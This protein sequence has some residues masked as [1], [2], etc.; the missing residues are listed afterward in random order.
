VPCGFRASPEDFEVEEVPSYG[1]SGEGDHL[2]LWIEKRCIPTFEAAR[3]LAG[4]LGIPPRDVGHAGL[5]DAHAVT[6]QQLSLPAPAPGDGAPAFDPESLVG[7]ELDGL[8]VLGAGRHG[9][10]LRRGHLRANRFRL[11]LRG[12]DAAGEAALREGLARLT[13][14]GA[15]NRF[16]AQRF[17]GPG[18]PTARLGLLLLCGDVDGFLRALIGGGPGE[19]PRRAEARARLEAGRPGDALAVMPRGLRAERAALGALARGRDAA[20]AARAVPRE[21]RQLYVSAAQSLVFN[22][23]SD[24]RVRAGTLGRL[25]VG[26]IAWLHDRGACFRVED[27]A[28]EQPRADHLELSPAG[29]L[30]GKKLLLAGGEVADRERAAL[31]AIGLGRSLRAV[32]AQ[33]HGQKGAALAPRPSGARRPYRV[34]V[35]EPSVKRLGDDLVLA[36]TLPPGAY[37]TTVCEELLKRPLG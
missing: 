13:R 10:K 25:A 36:F 22:Q 18:A 23:L 32:G 26:D 31:Q 17:G 2:L 1:P 24:D 35:T 5:K 34:P 15:P 11:R 20:A 6:R 28:T 30:F 19:D 12:V 16:G 29:P 4:H 21:L 8:R 33:G 37:A 27:P 14:G 9:H 7:L 3:R